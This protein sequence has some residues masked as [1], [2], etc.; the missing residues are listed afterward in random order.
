MCLRGIL[1]PFA[2][3][4]S[5]EGTPEKTKIYMKLYLKHY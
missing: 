2:E 3:L 1:K 4:H 5:M